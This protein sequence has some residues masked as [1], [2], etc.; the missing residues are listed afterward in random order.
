MAG[1][2]GQK[3]SKPSKVAAKYSEDF[4]GSMDRRCSAAIKL[5]TRLQLLTDDLG[6]LESLSYQQISLAKRAVFVEQHLE[7]LE[8]ALASGEDVSPSILHQAVNTL[9]GLYRTLGIHR[10]RREQSIK[11]Y[12]A[13]KQQERQNND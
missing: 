7:H 9:T 8:T 6:G 10:K 12:I 2:K 3:S 11:E 4:L 5:N 13:A 1:K